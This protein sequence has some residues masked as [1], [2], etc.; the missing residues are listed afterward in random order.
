MSAPQKRDFSHWRREVHTILTDQDPRLVAGVDTRDRD[1]RGGIPAAAASNGDLR[2]GDV[3]LGSAV[4]L[5]DLY[6]ELC[7]S[8][9]S[10]RYGGTDMESDVLNADEVI[11][12]GQ[13]F[14]DGEG[15]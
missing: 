15:H 11:A 14:R 2:T 10:P 3:E 7:E 8:K 12:A 5:S 13:R 9:Y 6:G 1:L 4:A